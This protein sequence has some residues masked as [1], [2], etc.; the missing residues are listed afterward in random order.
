MVQALK[1]VLAPLAW[2]FLI[3]TV[4]LE[5]I[6]GSFLARGKPLIFCCLHRD[7]LPSIMHVKPACPALLVSPS[8]DGDILIRTLGR[9]SYRFVRGGTGEDGNRAF[10]G[11]VK[12]LEQ[13]SSVGIAVDGPKGP[14]GTIQEGV[15]QLARLTGAAILPMVAQ[16]ERARV[17]S[18]WDRTVIPYPFTRVTFRHGAPFE[19]SRQAGRQDLDLAKNRLAGFFEVGDEQPCE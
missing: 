9:R 7:I 3:A 13:G 5:E 15:L 8:A 14:Y 6:P 2:R 4:K 19:I 17:L 16:P 11:L 12:M 10:L 18:T 1:L